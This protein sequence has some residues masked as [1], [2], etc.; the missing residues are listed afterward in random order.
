MHAT[1]CNCIV[2]YVAI[3]TQSCHVSYRQYIG[4]FHQQVTQSCTSDGLGSRIINTYDQGCN[5]LMKIHLCDPIALRGCSGPCNEINSNKY[6]NY[7]CTY[8]YI[9]Q[10]TNQVPTFG[11]GTIGCS[12]QFYFG[13]L[14]H[15]LLKLQK[16]SSY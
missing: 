7:T 11:I 6:Y 12:L 3:E 15:L 9:V 1:G 5:V 8:K 14:Y 16:Y 4:R 10:G 2:W 13:T